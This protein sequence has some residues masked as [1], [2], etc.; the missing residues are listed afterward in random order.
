MFEFDIKN[1]LIWIYS[2]FN[3]GSLLYLKNKDDIEIKI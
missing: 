2:Y 1:I 3:A